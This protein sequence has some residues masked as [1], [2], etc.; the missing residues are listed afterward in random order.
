MV[1]YMVVYLVEYTV[2]YTVE[3]CGGVDATMTSSRSRPKA[4]YQQ[5]RERSLTSSRS[6]KESAELIDWMWLGVFPSDVHL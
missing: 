6:A 2:E 5:N 1:K 4:C 3:Y